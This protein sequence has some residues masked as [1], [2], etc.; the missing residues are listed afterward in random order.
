MMPGSA[1]SCKKLSHTLSPAVIIH[2]HIYHEIEIH[3]LVVVTMEGRK[4]FVTQRWEENG[5]SQT[6]LNFSYKQPSLY[7]SHL[8]ENSL[9][10][11]EIVIA[12]TSINYKET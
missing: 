10:K 2:V 11:W 12:T 8:E 9:A 6:E 7:A 3:I 5:C 4:A 1:C